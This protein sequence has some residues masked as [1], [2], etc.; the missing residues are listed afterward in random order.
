MTENAVECVEVAQRRGRFKLGP[1]SLVIPKGIIFGLVGP[2]GAGKTTALDLLAG[3]GRADA[4]SITV[5]GLDITRHEVAAKR[6][7]AYA[8]PETTYVS[9]RR[10]GRAIDFVSGFYPD[11]DHAR[12]DTLL[13]AFGLNRGQLI[14]DLSFGEKNKLSLLMA[15]SRDPDLLMLDEPTTG[16]DPTTRRFLF[17]DLLHRMRNGDR[18][19]IIATHQLGELERF[20]DRVA[21][22]D[23][24]QIRL[25]ADLGALP[26][27]FTR[28][29]IALPDNTP[30]PL[31]PGITLLQRSAGRASL[32]LDHETI[33][34]GW[35]AGVSASIVAE[36]PLTLEE[37][38]LALVA[39]TQNARVPEVQS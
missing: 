29:D 38:Y 9:W 35:K 12:C 18:T 19:I 33:A 31:P 5:G 20:A 30:L 16:L 25:C 39:A 34:P 36:S 1:L 24:G 22:L 23:R 13:T 4:G 28:L 14:A 7:I 15:L 2:N 6:R 8:G 26:D 32:L 27:R 11:W 17:A 3:I 10:V 37:L 21:V